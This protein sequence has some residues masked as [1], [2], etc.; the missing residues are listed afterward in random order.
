MEFSD[1]VYGSD[2]HHINEGLMQQFHLGLQPFPAA[3]GDVFL[4][5]YQILI[6]PLQRVLEDSQ[7]QK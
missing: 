4:S 7:L 3:K 1:G 6:V 5:P 2:S